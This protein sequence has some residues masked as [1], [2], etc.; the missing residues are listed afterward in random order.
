MSSATE[1]Y[2]DGTTI[3]HYYTVIRQL[4]TGASCIVYLV[5]DNRSQ[6]MMAMKVFHRENNLGRD[7]E[8][9]I[10]ESLV[11]VQG[12][13]K[14]TE[15]IDFDNGMCG[16]IMPYYKNGTLDDYVKDLSNRGLNFD[17][18][19]FVNCLHI[20]SNIV[21]DYVRRGVCQCDLKPQNILVND[22]D[23]PLIA[24]FGIAKRL[25]SGSFTSKTPHEVYTT[26]YKSPNNADFRT[27]YSYSLITEMWALLILILSLASITQNARDR[28]YYYR[29]PTCLMF[30][31]FRWSDYDSPSSQIQIDK[32]V[33]SVFKQEKYSTFFKK[34]LN[35]N[36]TKSLIS[37]FDE[38]SFEAYIR[39]FRSDIQAVLGISGDAGRAGRAGCADH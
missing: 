38:A 17:E 36:K 13:I 20:L 35:V 32:A 37:S 8:T 14:Y 31:V 7:V 24:D 16:F 15:K 34:W 5:I 1:E 29:F 25:P 39:E 9:G 2:P 4:G 26:W 30:R 21:F 10:M 33:D 19:Y 3:G 11:D 12:V 6:S 27:K 18:G 22:D 28:K 23:M